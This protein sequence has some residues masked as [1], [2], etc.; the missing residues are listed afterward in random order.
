MPSPN[1]IATLPRIK[2]GKLNAL[3]QVLNLQSKVFTAAQE[4]KL[5]PRKLCLLTRAFCELEERKRI[6][7]GRPL[8][9]MLKP[10]PKTRLRKTSVVPLETLPAAADL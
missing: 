8:P 5:D 2:P 1:G 6:L 3:K 4:D 9:G 10:V 7:R